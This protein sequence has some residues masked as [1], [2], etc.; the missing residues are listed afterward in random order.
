MAKY[1]DASWHYEGDYPQDLPQENAATH[2]GMFLKWCI[3][4]G[5][6]S[7][8]QMEDCAESVE[9]LRRGEMTGARFLLQECDE[10]L[11]DED[12]SPL[13]CQFADAYYEEEGAFAKAQASYLQDYDAVFEARAQYPTLY[14]VEDTEENYAALA[15]KLDERF[16]QWKNFA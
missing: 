2:I 16:A 3:L 11:L 1:D 9:R 15:A 13:G 5:L 12:L 4:H 8:E 10:K 14:H 6:L 7:E